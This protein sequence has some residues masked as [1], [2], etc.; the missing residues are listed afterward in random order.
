MIYNVIDKK[1]LQVK[2][3]FNFKYLFFASVILN[4]FQYMAPKVKD[5]Q[6]AYVPIYVDTI[7]LIDTT[8]ITLDDSSIIAE[9]VRLD[10]VL[11]NVA[12]AQMKIETGH[13]TSSICKENKNIA[14]IRNSASA[15]VVGKNRG[16]CVYNSYRD[17]LRDYVRVQNKYLKN[18][19]GKYAEAEGYVSLIKKIE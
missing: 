19:D 12:L 18:I 5:L 14:G 13:F 7:S 10:C 3:V 15:Y 8:D 17:C 6:Y 4:A 1:T 11:P 2:K 16:H 9:L